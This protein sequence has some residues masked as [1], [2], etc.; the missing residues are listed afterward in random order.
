M[1]NGPYARAARFVWI[2]DFYFMAIIAFGEFN[3][4][5]GGSGRGE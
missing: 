4:L 3:D 1:I 2:A 5:V